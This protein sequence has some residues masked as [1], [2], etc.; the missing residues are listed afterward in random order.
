M[1]TNEIRLTIFKA[2]REGG[3]NKGRERKTRKG[4]RR[5]TSKIVRRKKRAE[6]SEGAE[7]LKE[8][9]GIGVERR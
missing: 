6:R 3:E 1:K 4:K 7:L 9:A 5:R 8:S 2:K